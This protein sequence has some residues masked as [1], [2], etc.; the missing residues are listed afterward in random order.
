MKEHLIPPPFPTEKDLPL[1]T[2][3]C[4]FQ[5]SPNRYANPRAQITPKLLPGF[6]TPGGGGSIHLTPPPDQ[7]G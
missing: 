7:Q 3:I 4:P 6:P 2:L 1:S 5:W